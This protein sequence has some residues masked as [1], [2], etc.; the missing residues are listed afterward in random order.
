MSLVILGLGN[1]L[2]TDDGV[3][4]HAVRALQADPPPHAELREIGTSV[5]DALSAVEAASMVIAIDAVDA[6]EVPGT[7]VRFD[8]DLDDARQAGGSLHDFD[9]PALVKLIDPAR[10]PRVVVVGIQPALVAP[11][12][13]LSVPVAAAL[14]AL[15]HVVRDLAARD[16]D[17]SCRAG[18]CD[19][20]LCVF[21]R[22]PSDTSLAQDE[23]EESDT[24]VARMRVGYRQDTIATSH[25]LVAA[26][27]VWSRE[28]EPPERGDQL[29][30]A[31]RSPGRHQLARH[32]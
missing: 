27:G 18:R 2:L 3:G 29:P 19:E 10:R 31:D 23:G 30:T 12:L 9:L 17:C 21:P 14:P 15:L 16:R 22:G 7:V 8:L 1:L 25:E 32:T 13:A 28:A 6:G 26:A 24:D 5:F 4:V 11:G 20:G